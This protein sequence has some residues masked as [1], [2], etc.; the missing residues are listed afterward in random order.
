MAQGKLEEARIT[1]LRGV[2]LARESGEVEPVFYGVLQSAQL[3]GL[4]GNRDAALRLLG[5]ADQ[6]MGNVGYPLGRA[7][8]RQ[9]ALAVEAL[10]LDGVDPSTERAYL[11]G[12]KLRLE[13]AAVTAVQ[14]HA[15]REPR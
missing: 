9:R 12:K 6:F 15:D 3:Q 11:E 7:A 14:A 1:L 10:L 13:E 2:Q 5:A 4:L 8:G